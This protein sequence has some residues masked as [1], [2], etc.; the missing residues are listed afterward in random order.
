MKKMILSLSLAAAAVLFA[1]C[2]S[3]ET[4]K[5]ADLNKQS[6]ANTGTTVAHVNVQN[7]GIYLFTIPLFA[8]STS[9]VGDIA[10]LK[11]TVNAQA[12]VPVLTAEAKK[13]GGKAVYDVAS[14]YSEFGFIFVKSSHA[15]GIEIVAPFL[16]LKEYGATQVEP[17]LFRK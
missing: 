6:I 10:V 3:V 8:G 16:A 7:W 12:V 15:I 9:S 1:G 11:D 17:S 14:Q 5:G 13:L 4:V 2:V